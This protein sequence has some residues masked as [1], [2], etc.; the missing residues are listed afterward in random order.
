MD[1]EKIALIAQEISFAYEDLFSDKDKKKLFH[2]L[3]DRYL[4][5]L[6]PEGK[7]EPYD[8]IV[9]LGR[10]N[11]EEFRQ[12]VSDLKNFSLIQ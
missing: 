10:N 7:M 9:Q 6:D 4:S 12:M 11:P 1:S 5:P 3:F 2:A 8:A